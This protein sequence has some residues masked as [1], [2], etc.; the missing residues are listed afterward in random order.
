MRVF[1]YARIVNG[2]R[3]VFSTRISTRVSVLKNTVKDTQTAY[4]V[5]SARVNGMTLP[6]DS[7]VVTT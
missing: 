5:I 7:K 1:P 6:S 4:L 2:C 3:R